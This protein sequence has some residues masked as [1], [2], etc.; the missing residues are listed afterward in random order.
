VAPASTRCENE[1]A[2]PAVDPVTGAVYI[3]YESN[4]FTSLVGITPCNT[5]P[6]SDVMTT[7]PLRCLPLAPH[8]ACGVSASSAVPVVSLEGAP[9]PGYSRFPLSDFPRLAVSDPAGTVSMVWNDS[10]NDPEG[11]ILLQSF[12]LGKLTPVQSEPVSLSQPVSGGL[13]FLPGLRGA[14]AS[15]NLDVVWYSRNSVNTSDTN[16]LG[17]IGISP[18]ATAPPSSDTLITSV[19]SNWANSVSF[20]NPNFGDYTDDSVAVTGTAPYVGST[21]YIAWSDGRIGVPQP[22][23]A[24]LPG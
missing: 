15:G 6:V 11:D 9:I 23:A 12:N 21:L 4:W 18:R 20:I 14:D 1:G 2:Y 7:I 3:A 22:F 8:A 13:N 19:P 17:A 10:R 24:H 16:V 5:V